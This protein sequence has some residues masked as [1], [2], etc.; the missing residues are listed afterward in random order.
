[1]MTPIRRAT[2]PNHPEKRLPLRDPHNLSRPEFAA[3]AFV[4]QA[5]SVSVSPSIRS[6]ASPSADH[7]Y[8]MVARS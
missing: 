4:F 3:D 2:K 7:R 8:Q 5:P 6:A 1:M